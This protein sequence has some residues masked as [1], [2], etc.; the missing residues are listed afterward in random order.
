MRRTRIW[1]PCSCASDPRVLAP[2]I[3]VSLRRWWSA[4]RCRRWSGRCASS[5]SA[6]TRSSTCSQTALSWPVTM[7]TTNVSSH[8]IIFTST[9]I[10]TYFDS[11]EVTEWAKLKK[12]MEREETIVI[13]IYFEFLSIPSN[14]SM[15]YGSGSSFSV[16]ALQCRFFVSFRFR[17]RKSYKLS[18][19]NKYYTYSLLFA[20]PAFKA[21]T[22]N[23]YSLSFKLYYLY[24]KWNRFS[25]CSVMDYSIQTYYFKQT[26]F[27]RIKWLFFI[28][29][30]FLFFQRYPQSH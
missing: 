1:S 14:W 9:H 6:R 20:S 22:G 12:Y 2:L 8:T 11:V 16:L 4:V 18:I 30:W 17:F 10:M 28:C 23:G 13:L 7:E 27:H 29:W 3:P 24:L 19:A 5:T 25:S 15:P 26:N 21:F